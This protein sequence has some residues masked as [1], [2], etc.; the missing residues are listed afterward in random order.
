MMT[1]FGNLE[2]G[3]VHK[4]Q[5]LLHRL[6]IPYRRVDVS[7][8]RGEPGRAEYLK[9]NPIG[10]VPALMLEDSD[11]ITE[12]GAILY[13]LVQGSKLWPGDRRAQTEVLRWMFFEQYS[14]EPALAVMRYLLLFDDAPERSKER[15]EELKPRAERALMAM[16]RQFKAWRFI[17][18]ETIT[19]ADYALYPYTAWAHEAGVSLED[20]PAIRRWLLQVES[21]PRFLPLMKDGAAETISFRDYFTQPRQGTSP[22]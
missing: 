1:L 16:E 12:S 5:M 4:V 2:S 3:N 13:Y 9:I 8:P 20:Y 10:K 21:E 14:H 7:Q 18:A 19:I 15:L 11:I 17:A 6:E 22:D